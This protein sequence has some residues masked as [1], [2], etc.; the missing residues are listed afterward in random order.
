M[1]K[2]NI[3]LGSEG[4]TACSCG[5]KD[6]TYYPTLHISGKKELDIPKEGVMTIRYRKTHSSVSEGDKSDPQYSCT[7]EARE[8]VSAESDEAESPTKRN[9]E[10]EDALDKLMDEKKK[11]YK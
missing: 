8:I 7:I 1:T 9:S 5:E 3:N 11:S 4:P 2:L 10:S 6:E